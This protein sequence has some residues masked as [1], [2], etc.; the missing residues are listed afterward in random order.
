MLPSSATTEAASQIG[1]ILVPPP[2]ELAA[3]FS[4]ALAGAAMGVERRFDIIGIATLAVVTGLGGGIIR[5][6]LLQDYG[7]YA[8]QNTDVLLT[9]LLAAIIGF[10]FVGAANKMR[11]P[12]MVLDTVAL[13]LFALIGSDKALLAG[14][15]IL[16][17][18][19][20]GMIT[21]TGGG[22]LRDLLSNVQPRIMQPGGLVASA[23]AVGCT[24]Y[25]LMVSW[26]NIVKPISALTAGVLVL[27]LRSLSMW[28]GWTTPEPV[29]LTPRLMDAGRSLWGR[30]TSLLPSSR[31][32]R[33]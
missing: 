2:F 24:T 22:V 33:R 9:T 19:L 29:D 18:I 13:A 8:F 1:R 20:I 28:L 31:R 7:I 25:V 16:P 3:T 17:A 12:L 26:L 11:Q 10:F 6:M 4:G 23:A 14:L 30:A 21:A 27:L 15:P 5:D 32:S